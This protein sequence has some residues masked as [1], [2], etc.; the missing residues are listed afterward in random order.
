MFT[1]DTVEKANILMDTLEAE[2]I[3]VRQQI[4]V[5]ETTIATTKDREVVNA[6]SKLAD[7]LVERAELL[8][9]SAIWIS[10]GNLELAET[11]EI[12]YFKLKHGVK[13]PA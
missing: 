10:K 2:L 12:E 6:M 11:A 1:K 8:K 3:E 13:V 4:R 7:N 5:I 9:K